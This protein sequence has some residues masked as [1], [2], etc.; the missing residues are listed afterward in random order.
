MIVTRFPAGEW[1]GCD[2]WVR[3]PCWDIR[4][5][6]ALVGGVVG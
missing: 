3:C 4:P 1:G 5:L 2:F 6:A